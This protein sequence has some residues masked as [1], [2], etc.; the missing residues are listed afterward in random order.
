MKQLFLT[1][2][3][4]LALGL[5]PTVQAQTWTGATSSD[6][7][8]GSN[9]NG[10]AVPGSDSTVFVDTTTPNPAVI[11][12]SATAAIRVLLV[13]DS[14]TGSL[15][16]NNGGTLTTTGTSF[17]GTSAG[18]VGTII[19]SGPGTTWADPGGIIVGFDGNGTMIVTNGAQVIPGANAAILVGDN[20]GSVGTLTISN[21]AQ[22]NAANIQLG[23]FGGSGTLNIG[24][25]AGAPATAPGTLNG[26]VIATNVP[27]LVEFNHTDTSG[28]YIFASQIIG[29][30]SVNVDSGTTALTAENTYT[31]GTTISAG[32][33]QLGD[34]GISGSI[35]GDVTNNGT[36]A[37]NRSDT[38]TFSGTVSGTGGVSQIGP[39]TTILTGINTYAGG[40]AI[41]GGVLEVAQD[42]NLG[43]ALAA[44][45]FDGG[46]L[47]TTE[48]FTMNRATTLNAG[49]GTFE[50]APDTT[51]TQHGV[52]A[53]PGILGK[54]GTGTLYLTAANLYGGGTHLDA[55]TILVGNAAALGT[56]T[57]A[58]AADTTLDFDASYTLA[59]AITLS[60]ADSINATSGLTETL[61][62]Q[63]GDGTSA[64]TLIKT[65]AGT[66]ILTAND[67]YS[68]GTTITA[69]TLQL[70]NGG[71]SGAI[72]GDVVDNGTLSFNRSDI[73]T[74]AGAISGPGGMSQIGPGTTILTS[75]SDYS[76][77]TTVAQGTLAAGA[78][79]SFSAA[80]SVTVA[81]SG[82]LAL[83]SFN[84]T[85][86]ALSNQGKV[87]LPA[88]GSSAPGTVLTVSGDYA[89]GGALFINT[90]LN[91]DASL[92]DRLIVHGATSG[93]TALHVNNVGGIGAQTVNGI[94]VIE[95]DGASNGQFNLIG[96][97]VTPSNEQAVVA[98]AYAY[99]LHQNGIS[100]P[101]DGDWYLRSELTNQPGP[102]FNPGVSLYES[103]PQ[104]LLE[105]NGLPTMQQR[106]GNRFWLDGRPVAA[107]ESGQAFIERQ[108]I[109]GRIEASHSSYE[110]A[111]TTSD[112]SRD[113]DLYRLQ[114]GIDVGVYEAEDRSALIGA[115]TFQ[116]GDASADINS[117]NGDGDIDSSGFGV[118]ATLTWLDAG[119]FYVD[120]Q[121]QLNLYD[122]DLRSD[123]AGR[124]LVSNNDATGY[125]LSI[126][127][128]QRVDLSEG[129]SITPQAQLVYSRVDF[130]SFDDTFGAAAQ[131]EDNDS[132]RGRAGLTLDSEHN[133]LGDDG[134]ASRSHLYGIANLY[135]EFLD[136]TEVNVGGVAFANRDERLWG[137]LGAGGSYDW[138]N[139]KYSL[140]GEASVDTSLENSTDSYGVH[141][142]LG[143]RVKF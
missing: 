33:L 48:S 140:Y 25:P 70:G 76:G 3:T 1:T 125:A 121:A 65:G 105:L 72:V 86:A 47:R 15:T 99:T 90:T 138:D 87:R 23:R 81:P 142:T 51:L 95:V 45:S 31:G 30:V 57:L 43:A 100:T 59:N 69:G 38:M 108:G 132:L 131:D 98:G 34:G 17:I 141:A 82:T 49:G 5:S 44:L 92:T 94:K 14:A 40:T 11:A 12:S 112:A 120:A 115:L 84:Q 27:A 8:T 143:M 58:M 93:Q 136:G 32:I 39:G 28:N 85:V 137:G 54:T 129:L 21:G 118:G 102:I 74:F 42:V 41:N 78:D 89:G 88:T 19:V 135:Y 113:I 56:G 66:V 73:Y 111:M 68:G 139:E 117:P 16:V 119:G 116:Y 52:I 7:F 126:E 64:G 109:W 60:G 104:V 106:V 80:S 77:A 13:G 75:T 67:T 128:G 24:A 29:P 130:D 35:V 26:D 127:S 61:T 22:V 133:W 101:T 110:P 50:V 55:G 18:S 62:G 107:T 37:F 96:N 124:K 123:E 20:S 36:L 71:A 97:F 134:T 2:T 53:G 10:G 114:A 122:S 9:W 83:Q 91:D 103:Y 6:W 63:I 79:N 46:T 4:V